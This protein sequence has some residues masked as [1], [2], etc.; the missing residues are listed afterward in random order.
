MDQMRKNVHPYTVAEQFDLSDKVIEELTKRV[1]A[2]G[3][4]IDWGSI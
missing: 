2:D 1:E 3:Y 4:E